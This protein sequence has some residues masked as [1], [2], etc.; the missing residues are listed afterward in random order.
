M[1]NLELEDNDKEVFAE[2]E[3]AGNVRDNSVTDNSVESSK[4]Q[5]ANSLILNLVSTQNEPRE[6]TE[7]EIT[8]EHNKAE[9]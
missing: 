4:K 1:N 9:S 6:K 8:S 7:S 2:T 5:E 3:T